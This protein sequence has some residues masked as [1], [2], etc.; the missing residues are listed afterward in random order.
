MPF[1]SFHAP[2]FIV[3]ILRVFTIFILVLK[4][5]TFFLEKKLQTNFA[6]LPLLILL[7]KSFLHV[8]LNA[9]ACKKINSN[10]MKNMFEKSMRLLFVRILLTAFK[11]S[12]T[13]IL[14]A[15]L[16]IQGHA[17]YFLSILY[18]LKTFFCIIKRIP[19]RYAQTFLMR[20]MPV[21][22]AFCLPCSIE[23]SW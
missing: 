9:P 14:K 10:F 23:N 6:N 12:V 4:N 3:D 15:L 16:Y 19:D 5:T 18:L 11:R 8:G 1:F 13:G 20:D 22:P 21:K 2:A 17:R 7:F